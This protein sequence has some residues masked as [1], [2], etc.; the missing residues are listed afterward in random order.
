MARPRTLGPPIQFRLPIELHD[1]AA[2]RAEAHGVTVDEYIRSRF[3]DALTKHR[4]RTPPG[5]DRQVQPRWK[6]PPKQG[7]GSTV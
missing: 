5:T 6:T 7:K 3:V 2:E 4:D 1:I